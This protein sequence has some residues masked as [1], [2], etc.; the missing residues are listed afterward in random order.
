MLPT[1]SATASG[2]S[3]SL[4]VDSVAAG[5]EAGTVVGSDMFGRAF[6]RRLRL[7]FFEVERSWLRQ[8][9]RNN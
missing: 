3:V 1:S 6:S 7:C 2:A 5:A 9:A 4:G 8:Q